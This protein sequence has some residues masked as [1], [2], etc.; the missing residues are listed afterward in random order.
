[1][2]EHAR[3]LF[4]LFVQS[5][6]RAVFVLHQRIYNIIHP[7]YIR[8]EQRSNKSARVLIKSAI[9]SK[10]RN[11]SGRNSAGCVYYTECFTVNVHANYFSEQLIYSM[12]NFW[13]FWVY[14][15]RPYFNDVDC[16]IPLNMNSLW[17]WIL[18]FFKHE[19]NIFFYGLLLLGNLMISNDHSLYIFHTYYYG[20]IT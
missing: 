16:F 18:L 11:S 8:R 10:I 17:R 20:P 9:I 15:S 14:T 19:N 7:V 5:R 3:Y 1:M 12:S 4:V 6:V 2:F 13:D